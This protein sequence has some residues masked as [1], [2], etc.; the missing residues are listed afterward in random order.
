MENFKVCRYC[1]EAI[2]SR[3]YKNATETHYI[4]DDDTET[5][6][7]WCKQWDDVLYE[8]MKRG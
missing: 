2:Q 8:I 7:D 1:L 5:V 4:D 6:C 3:G